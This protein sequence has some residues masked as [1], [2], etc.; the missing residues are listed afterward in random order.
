[1]R[2]TAAFALVALTA[3]PAFAL[4][5]YENLGNTGCP[6][7]EVFPLRDL[8]N[9]SCQN[10]WYVRNNIYDDHGYCFKTAR[11]QA[12]F[13][14]SDCSVDDAGDLDLNSNEVRNIDNIKRI[15]REKGCP[16]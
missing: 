2:L 16:K 1:M 7:K 11:A 10:L 8:R 3:T 15:E 14:N 12:E 13:D 5:C 6:H 9:L 4:D